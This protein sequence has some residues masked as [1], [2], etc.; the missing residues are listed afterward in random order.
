MFE[1]CETCLSS[2]SRAK[3]DPLFFLQ[4]KV[5]NENIQFP[6]IENTLEKLT[7]EHVWDIQLDGTY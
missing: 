2:V 6:A 7:P 1:N 5:Q 3:G 4:K